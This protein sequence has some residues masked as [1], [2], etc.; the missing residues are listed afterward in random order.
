MALVQLSARLC[1]SSHWQVGVS[2]TPKTK[3]PDVSAQRSGAEATELQTQKGPWRRQG[4]R[5]PEGAVSLRPDTAM[6]N[7]RV[8]LILVRAANICGVFP[9]CCHKCLVYIISFDP[10]KT[11]GIGPIIILPITLMGK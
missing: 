6:A 1:S 11:P 9:M 7:L 2:I 8:T 4:N 3:G 5:S 10:C